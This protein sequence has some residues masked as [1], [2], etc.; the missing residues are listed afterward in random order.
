MKTTRFLIMLSAFL[1]MISSVFTLTTSTDR[2]GA[3]INIGAM[4]CL[5]LAITFMNFKNKPDHRK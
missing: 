5:V 2:T 1:I 4:F 3:Y